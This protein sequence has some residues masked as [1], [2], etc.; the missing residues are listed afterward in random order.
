MPYFLIKGEFHLFYQGKRHVG[1]QPD[2]DSVWFKPKNP[3]NL[4][5]I[6]G[7]QAEVNAGGFVQLRFEGI[8][9]LEL[10]FRGAHQERQWAARARDFTLNQ[11]GFSSVE[12]S[13]EKMLS[14]KT[15]SPHPRVGYILTRAIDP[16]GRPVSFVYAGAS[17]HKD[18]KQVFLD[19]KALNKSINAKLAEVG[20]AFPAFYTGLPTDLR[21]RINALA[22]S[23]RKRGFWP[24]DRTLKPTTIADLA[25]LEEL[26]LWP[27]LFRRLVTYFKDGNKG[28][29]KFE[30]WLRADKDRDD[31]LWI[32]P[33]SELGNLHDVIH[34]A[35]EKLSLRY[36]PKD[37]IVVPR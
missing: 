28:V 37:L 23:A 5:D 14:I 10:H 15:A 8:D 3:R 13:G 33:K 24:D 36:S 26:V 34:L 19:V 7:R 30:E 9:A 21:S 2:G 1:S 11:L 16:Y 31:V 18:G 32:V 22:R 25:K 12:Y 27:K 29:A 20:N 6:G 17:N 4:K 35:G